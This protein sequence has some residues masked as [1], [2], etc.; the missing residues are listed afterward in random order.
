MKSNK[1]KFLKKI[2]SSPLLLATLITAGFY[3]K[4]E[5]CTRLVFTGDKN[6]VITARSMDW[7]DEIPTNLWIFPRGMIRNGGIGPN[8]LTWT[9]KYG[10]VITSSFD[11]ATV[12]GV[13]EKGL[14]ANLLWLAESQ[15]SAPNS[16]KNGLAISIWGQFILDNFAS[17]NEAVN[18]MKKN[19]ISVYTD[20][21]PGQ[22]R[23]ATLHLAISDANGDSAIVE[24]IDGKQVIYHNKKYNVM[25]NSPTYDKQLAMEEYWKNIGGLS[26]LPGTN[27]AADRFARASFYINSIPKN[28]DDNI[29]VAST[30]SVIRNVSVPFGLS[31]ED[32][33]EISSTRWRTLYDHKRNLYFFE[34]ALTPNIFWTNLKNIDFSKETGVVKKLDLGKGQQRILSGDATKDYVDTKPFVFKTVK[35]H[36]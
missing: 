19:P 13:N 3:F 17:V 36:Q 1:T 9:S 31:T 10:S 22:N 6:Q 20:N 29:A 27:R 15:H 18:Y 26:F 23:L 21:V 28:M 24:Y 11:I 25:T 5:A 4:A 32:S 30:F 8:S 2:I 7:K 16:K 14:A 12:D 33:P 35:I 34:S